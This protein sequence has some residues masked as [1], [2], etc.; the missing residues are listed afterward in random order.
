MTMQSGKGLCLAVFLMAMLIC[1]AAAKDP[2]GD[3]PLVVKLVAPKGLSAKR[4]EVRLYRIPLPT[5]NTYRSQGSRFLPPESAPDPDATAKIA[6]GRAAF[7]DL[8]AGIW[9]VVAVVPGCAR[10]ETE[11][12]WAAG[13]PP[14]EIELKLDAAAILEG[15]VL[16]G[17]D[18][19]LTGVR[20]SA[21]ARGTS[22][23]PSSPTR[24][25][26][27]VTGQDGRYRMEGLA[28]GL[29]DLWTQRSGGLVFGGPVIR[30]PNVGR[31]DL[32]LTNGAI[33]W[34]R[35]TAKDSGKPVAGAIVQMT[36]G[37]FGMGN[38]DQALARAV[39]GPNGRYELHTCR[40]FMNGGPL[41]ST[42]PGFA[43]GRLSDDGLW[44]LREGEKYERDF[45]LEREAVVKG[46]VTGPDGPVADALVSLWH[47]GNDP[48]GRLGRITTRTSADGKW[49][50]P[51]LGAGTFAIEVTAR[52]ARSP[53]TAA[54]PP[55]PDGP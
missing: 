37:S 53:R 23:G 27:A 55:L 4:G 11:V 34:G 41:K 26:H 44:N 31:I 38:P 25:F 6:R 16:L 35:V 13:L 22:F 47:K 48:F 49:S 8:K 9:R 51:G 28:P 32:H 3:P 29:Y 42:A 7:R 21:T 18:E 33:I 46:C 54:S 15:R 14:L 5:G 10:A 20:V 19:H 12:R 24:H 43:T 1:P 40:D 30:V 2:A 39:S 50:V 36:G 17:D 45:V 52:R